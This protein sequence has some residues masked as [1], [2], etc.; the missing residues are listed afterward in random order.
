VPLARG[1]A[2]AGGV[3]VAVILR[4]ENLTKYINVGNGICETSRLR[5]LVVVGNITCCLNTLWDVD[6]YVIV[7][8][9]QINTNSIVAWSCKRILR[10][11]KY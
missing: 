3:F 7:D 4:Y 1:L 8:D 2:V 10:P 6:S 5:L 9:R 11:M